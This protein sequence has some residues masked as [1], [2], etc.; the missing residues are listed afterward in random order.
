MTRD[1]NRPNILAILS[2]Q[3]SK[4]LVGA[5][6]NDIVRT[7]NLDALAARGMRF[8]ACYCPSP[9][10]V[11]SRMSFMTGRTPSRNRV[12]AN[13]HVLSSAV[14]TW[15][16]ALGAG[17]Y[18]TAL[19][20]RMHFV[21]PDGRHGFEKRPVGEFF[22]GHLGAPRRGGPLFKDIPAS[23]SGQSRVSVEISGYG[24]T[25]YQEFDDIITDAA[26]DYLAGKARGSERP[27][28]AV[29]GYV[30]PHCPFFCP[31]D[32]FDYYYERV[33]VPDHRQDVPQAVRK[34]RLLRGIEEPL[35]EERTRI[36]RA[37]YFGMCEYLDRN[38]GRVLDALESAELAENTLVVYTSDHGE[39][40]GEHGCWWK[41]NYYE[42]SVGVPLIAAMPGVVP[43]GSECT[44]PCNLMDLGPTFA[45][46]TESPAMPATDG[47]SILPLLKGEAAPEWPDETFSEHAG[48]WHDCPSRMVRS[49]PW[50]LYAYHDQTPAVLF[51][52]E[53]DPDELLDLSSDPA[54]AEVK[55]S[56]LER[57][58]DG[59]DPEAVLREYHRLVED[60]ELLSE[61]GRVVKPEHEDAL[62]IPFGVED[63]TVL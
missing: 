20:G 19:V 6:G 5:C 50:K 59:W 55:K 36:A 14:P 43:E 26:C 60:A 4:H 63:V 30:L 51:N 9:L 41:A 2:D 17:G 46:L 52:L 3:H 21:G 44:R 31:K 18:E 28:A 32:L 61:W 8:D 38:V 40:A 22:S 27:F 42:S 49:G 16:H 39:S 47:R 58:H 34:F 33:D 54:C 23:T 11:P 29:V 57:L 25:T 24:R 15:A 37:A 35:P 7:P 48:G 12:W 10:C 45:E 13:N 1:G 62:E 53:D 56:L